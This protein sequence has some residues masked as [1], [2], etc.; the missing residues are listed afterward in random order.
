MAYVGQ[1]T[2]PSRIII[3]IIIDDDSYHHHHWRLWQWQQFLQLNSSGDYGFRS[4]GMSPLFPTKKAIDYYCRQWHIVLDCLSIIK[5]L[6]L[7]LPLMTL[8][9][10]EP[11]EFG[12]CVPNIEEP[13]SVPFFFWYDRQST[14]TRDTNLVS[15]DDQIKKYE[16]KKKSE[17]EFNLVSLWWCRYHLIILTYSCSPIWFRCRRLRGNRFYSQIGSWLHIS[18]SLFW[19]FVHFPKTHVV[20]RCSLA[21]FSFVFSSSF[22]F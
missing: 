7:L 10:S 13:L 1:L 9:N 5:C 15:S 17:T 4:N 18:R 16:N 22:F 14:V 3:I 21:L 12:N 2:V 19:L 8:D 11:N 6:L 20:N